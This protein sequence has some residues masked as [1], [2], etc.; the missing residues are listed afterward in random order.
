VFHSLSAAVSLWEPN[1]FVFCPQ[2]EP[3]FVESHEIAPCA[4]ALN[5]EHS[6]WFPR[7]PDAVRD[8]RF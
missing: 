8:L 3:Q 1:K 2:G 6:Q 7:Q 4:S 5:S